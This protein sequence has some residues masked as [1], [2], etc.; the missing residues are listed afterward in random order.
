MSRVLDDSL[1]LFSYIIMPLPRFVR[2][3]LKRGGSKTFI[4]AFGVAPK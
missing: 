2:G 3:E 4:V 1:N